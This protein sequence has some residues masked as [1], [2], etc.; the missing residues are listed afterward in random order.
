[1]QIVISMKELK[2]AVAVLSRVVSRKNTLPIL[3][4]V[5]VSGNADGVL[6]TGTILSEYL[7]RRVVRTT[8]GDGLTSLEKTSQHDDGDGGFI[9]DFK[10][11][12]EFLKGSKKSGDVTF[13]IAD[14]QVLGQYY[15]KRVVN[16]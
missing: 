8:D 4:A 3:S 5:K 14:G 1:M 7:T 16:K 12:R 10:E 13:D 6:I 11:L 15:Y 2:D 9:I